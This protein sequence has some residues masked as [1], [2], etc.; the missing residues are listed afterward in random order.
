MMTMFYEKNRSLLMKYFQSGCKKS[1]EQ[2]IGIEI[3]HFIVK[4]DT[5]ESVSYYGEHGVGQILKRLESQFSHVSCEKEHL[6]GLWNDDYSIT[7]EP[8]S[9]FEISIFPQ[10]DILCVEKIY[11]EFLALM[12]PILEEYGYEMMTGGYQPHDKV[13]DLPLIPKKRYQYMDEYF[14]TSGTTGRNMMR[15]TASAQVSVDYFDEEDF[16]RKMRAAY[17][18]MPA[19]K[20]LTDN[21]HIFEG[22]EYKTHMVRTM[23]WHNVDNKRC[24]IVPGLFDKG[25]GFGAYADYVMNMPLIF[26]PN[27]GNPLYVKDMTAKEVW[28]EKEMTKEDIEHVLSM[29]FVDVRLKKYLEIRGADSMPFPYVRAYALMIHGIFSNPSAI[30][31]ILSWNVNEKDIRKAEED[32]MVHG[33]DGVIYGQPAD[34]HLRKVMQLAKENLS[35]QE[36]TWLQP[37]EQIIDEKRTLAKRYEK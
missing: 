10:E 30:E 20:L 24:G 17:S 12:D 19:I 32:L 36:I 28:K 14:K 5:K 2:M 11:D 8:A 18:L 31:E 26:L 6:I 7:L 25:F 21:T 33:F 9:Q 22:Q 23:I 1:K 34:V 3:E 37:L 4:K 29:T 27:D 35:E 15:G 13:D 16:V